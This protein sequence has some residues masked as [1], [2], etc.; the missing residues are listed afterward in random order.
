MEDDSLVVNANGEV[1]FGQHETTEIILNVGHTGTKQETSL[2]IENNSNLQHEEDSVHVD[3][4]DENDIRTSEAEVRV[5]T[6]TTIAQE[7]PT[8]DD[9]ATV[10]NLLVKIESVIDDPS[11]EYT[12]EPSDDKGEALEED[13]PVVI[14][15][16]PASLHM[17]HV[18]DH[19]DT[20]QE[21]DEHEKDAPEKDMSDE[22]ESETQ[23]PI[24]EAEVV[25]VE[26]TPPAL[27]SE[28]LVEKESSEDEP[29]EDDHATVQSLL[30]NIESVIDNPT[31]DQSP[32]PANDNKTEA[33]EE[34]APVIVEKRPVSLHMEHVIEQE[35]RDQQRDRD[36]RDS[37]DRKVSGEPENKLKEPVLEE[38]LVVV[39]RTPV[40][41]ESEILIEKE[42]PGD[43][44]R[45]EDNTTVETLLVNIESVIGHPSPDRIEEP[46]DENKT[47]ALEEDAP[48]VIEKRPLS[49]HMERVIYQDESVEKK[50][51]DE[52]E[53]IAETDVMVVEKT[54][55]A[56]A[57]EMLVEKEKDESK[58]EDSTTVET[59]LVNIESVIDHPLPD[60][61]EEPVDENKTEALEEDVP[62]VIEKRP[63][64]LHMEQVIDQDERVEKKDRDEREPIAETDVMVIEKT[65]VAF[66][67]EMLVEKEEDES[68]EEDSTTVETLLVNIESVIDHPSLDRPEEQA[69]ESTTEALKEDA[70]VVI[71]KR[72]VC[73]HIEQVMVTD[74]SDVKLNKDLRKPI[75]EADV[76][77]VE[78]TPVALESEI[79]VENKDEESK[80]HDSTTV[81]SLLVN[82]ESVIDYASPERTQEPSED[83]TDALEE[84]APV[85]IEKR[86]VSPRMEHLIVQDDTEEQK[87]EEGKDAHGKEVS[88]EEV[89]EPISEEELVVVKKT[90]V[91]LESDILVEKESAEDEPKEDDTSVAS[92]LLNIESAIDV[93]SPEHTEEPNEDKEE[94]LEEDAPLV[95]EKRP[96]SLNIEHVVGQE[97]TEEQKDE[98]AK[99]ANQN[100]INIEVTESREPIAE[101]EV[102]VVEKSPITLESE[103]L[104][105][106]ESSE[107]EPR[108]S[109]EATVESLLVNIESVIDHTSPEQPQQPA[110]ENKAQALEEDAPVVIE[111][112]PVSVHME[113]VIGQED[114]E[115][116]KEDVK[117]APEKDESSEQVAESREPIEEADVVV[118]EKTPPALQSEILVEKE[119]PEVDDNATVDSLLVQIGSVIDHPVPKQAQEPTDEDK[120][121]ALEEDVPVVVEKRPASLHIQQMLDQDGD[122]NQKN[123]YQDEQDVDETEGTTESEPVELSEPILEAEFVVVEKPPTVLQTEMLVEQESPEDDSAT[124]ES[125]LVN[126]ESVIDDTSLQQPEQRRKDVEDTVQENVPPVVERKASE[127]HH[128]LLLTLDTDEH[129]PENAAEEMDVRETEIL[130]D[131]ESVKEAED[132]NVETGEEAKHA[133]VVKTHEGV[134]RVTMTTKTVAQKIET[135]TEEVASAPTIVVTETTTTEETLKSKSY[136]KLGHK[137]DASEETELLRLVL[138]KR[139]SD[140]EVLP[141]K[142]KEGSA[143]L[144]PSESGILDSKEHV[145]LEDTSQAREPETVSTEPEPYKDVPDEEKLI[146]DKRKELEDVKKAE[147]AEKSLPVAEDEQG[148]LDVDDED[149]AD[150]QKDRKKGKKGLSSPQCKCCSLM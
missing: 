146:P 36:E 102:V 71:E 98:D 41:L 94:A 19:D 135:S 101:A 110:D 37:D 15:K 55:V 1:S 68:K 13:A 145:P 97:E 61:I 57:S 43:E 81:K 46:V 74:E 56:F 21:S 92:L 28:L 12:K 121:E 3:R 150:K 88:A 91:A 29:K 138:R 114:T 93:T 5:V 33:L 4:A 66:A 76:V 79:L 139:L 39:E 142:E 75:T 11:P 70:P 23:K 120:A 119:I 2:Y 103:I 73:L 6:K 40:A 122:E 63:V 125:L 67:S 140:P 136:T 144:A 132:A 24:S 18:L 58:E 32:E 137:D 14:E 148:L 59:L 69:D 117:D 130:D 64:S 72:P 89:K 50:D 48:V 147:D 35:E 106:K 134:S 47:D 62:V 9:N 20:E 133:E 109:D 85:V 131:E 31:P 25:V 99:D 8:E 22:H 129:K 141:E 149:N 52:R 10:E 77:V 34:E 27:E 53:P 51:R 116:Q 45:E 100:E 90:P 108:E 95:I 65:S 107:D 111:K 30:V 7:E 113:H 80:E 104:V 84:D 128:E 60:R 124:V 87:D 143:P 26:R 115:Q 42:G 82:V 86:P 127:T 105:E 78:K 83:K 44:P 123:A 49:V 118:V 126:I 17:E 16:R 38:E 96:V 112:R 54:S